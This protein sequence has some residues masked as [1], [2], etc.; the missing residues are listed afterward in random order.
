MGSL[1]LKN[2]LALVASAIMMS[3]CAQAPKC[4]VQAHRGGAGLMPENTF[5]SMKNALELGV[6][7]LEMDFWM[8]ADHKLVV[9]HDS[10]FHPRYATRPDG[11]LIA[12]EDPKEYLYT[13]PYDSIAKYDVGQRATEVWPEKE[14][15]PE[16]KPLA[17]EL[18]A[19]TE[20]YARELGR[21]LPWYNIEMKY[22]HNEGEG[23][24]W[25]PINETIDSSMALFN[26]LGILDRVI[27]QCFDPAGLEYMNTSYPDAVLAFLTS[28]KVKTYE[29][30]VS[31][32]TFKPEWISPEFSVVTGEMVA[33]CHAD[34]IRIVPWTPDQPEDITRM[35]EYGCD[36]VITNYPDRMIRILKDWNKKK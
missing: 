27:V 8:S 24:L 23:E 5:S 33:K 29:D 13:M 14:C 12:K 20:S 19:F 26:R 15:K 16:V 34:G 9:S 6:G 36:A 4:D 31:Q 3:A 7:T 18:L 22:S 1:K 17:E 25:A 21:E 10:Y 28:K 30:I 35:I 2:A 32:L 11:T